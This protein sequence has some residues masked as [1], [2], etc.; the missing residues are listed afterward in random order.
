MN[1]VIVLLMPKWTCEDTQVWVD[2]D[3][4]GRY[5]SLARESWQMA[6]CMGFLV[7]AV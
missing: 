2:Q 3:S 4:S 6:G 7:W 1:A 5:G